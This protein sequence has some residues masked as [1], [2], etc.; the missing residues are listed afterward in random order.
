MQNKLNYINTGSK[1]PMRHALFH[2]TQFKNFQL[3]TYEASIKQIQPTPKENDK[4]G[5]SNNINQVHDQYRACN[6]VPSSS[7]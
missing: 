2:F 7:R 6:L 1:N 4:N 5:S 3:N